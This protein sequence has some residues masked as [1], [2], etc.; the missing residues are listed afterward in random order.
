M[1]SG[2]RAL[3]AFGATIVVAVV[4]VGF[5]SLRV[6]G[7]RKT[8]EQSAKVWF[9]D[10]VSKRLYAAAR[11]AIPPDGNGVRAI[12]VAYP[13]EGTDPAKR[14]IAYLEKCT[15]ALKRLLE[16]LKAARSARQPVTERIPPRDA[17][18]FQ[19]NT[20]VSSV[21]ESDWHPVNTV[22]GRRTTSAWRSWVGP[23][24]EHPMVCVP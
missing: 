24:G 17:Q 14:K 3:L 21:T 18:Y 6:N 12:V 19:D 22:E 10:L 13:G 8:G 20:L 2:P 15:P 1:N 9:Y 7:F 5:A 23:R 16:Q 11:D 4:A